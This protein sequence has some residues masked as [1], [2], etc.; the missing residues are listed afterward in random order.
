MPPHRSRLDSLFEMAYTPQNTRQNRRGTL[1]FSPQ[2]EMRSSSIPLTPV[3]SL[4][5]P[6]N[7]RVF[8]TSQRH[9]E[10]SLRSPSQVK[11]TQGFLLQFEKDLKVPPS[12]LL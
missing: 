2:L 4:E 10:S 12:M 9:Q 11:G 3:E 8:L 1:R 6:P 5:A 7:S